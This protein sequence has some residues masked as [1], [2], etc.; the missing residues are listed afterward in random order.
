MDTTTTTLPHNLPN[1]L[2]QAGVSTD[3]AAEVMLLLPPRGRYELLNHLTA[4]TLDV[5]LA[6]WIGDLAETL[7]TPVADA[8]HIRDLLTHGVTR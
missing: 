7:R 1:A 8:A 5:L 2:D 3:V 6:Q 4:G